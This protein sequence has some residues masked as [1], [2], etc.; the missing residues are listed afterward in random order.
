MNL[1]THS[2]S[3]FLVGDFSMRSPR[4]NQNAASSRLISSPPFAGDEERRN[5]ASGK[6]S[7]TGTGSRL[8][9]AHQPKPG[10]G[11]RLFNNECQCH[12]FTNA[13]RGSG[14]P[15]AAV[16]KVHQSYLAPARSRVA[17]KRNCTNFPNPAIW[18]R[19]S[20]P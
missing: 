1:P 12:G 2:H 14:D 3:D 7:G 16:F 8:G 17:L 20:L 19:S 9:T 11:A 15:Y 5:R 6:R 10:F 13:R 18:I 4:A